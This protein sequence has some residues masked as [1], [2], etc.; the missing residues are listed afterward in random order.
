MADII[1]VLPEDE[2]GRRRLYRQLMLR[3]DGR[4]TR[5]TG[6]DG[7]TRLYDLIAL[8]ELENGGQILIAFV[9]DAYGHWGNIFRI[10]DNPKEG[11]IRL[12]CILDL[13]YR[14]DISEFVYPPHALSVAELATYVIDRMA[15]RL[16][17]DPAAAAQQALAN[18]IWM[19][20]IDWCSVRDELLELFVVIEGSNQQH[21]IPADFLDRVR[22]LPGVEDDV[23]TDGSI[24]DN[25][26]ILQLLT[27]FLV[28]F[29]RMSA[30]K[31][32]G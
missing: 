24:P 16:E 32:N 19:G 4:P 12:D 14:L 6:P 1:A 13:D 8:R 30:A 28:A 31:A 15:L 18:A 21:D 26:A 11:E 29:G 5:F 2:A 20:L 27:I 7:I 17:T 25:P 23:L 3:Q 22:E 9:I 10:V